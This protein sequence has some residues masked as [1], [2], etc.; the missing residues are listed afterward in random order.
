MDGWMDG[1]M[2][3]EIEIESLGLNI[4]NEKKYKERR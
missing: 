2:K 3:G 1:G 4:L